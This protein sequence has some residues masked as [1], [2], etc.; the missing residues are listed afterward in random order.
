V[1][2][3]TLLSRAPDRDLGKFRSEVEDEVRY[4]NISI[5]EGIGASQHG[6]GMV[7]A[8]IVETVARDERIVIPIGCYNPKYGV[9]LSLPSVVG[10]EGVLEIIEPE[11]SAD[12]REKLERSADRLKAALN[13]INL[14][15]R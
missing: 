6:I 4:A 1:A 11:L 3:S 9:T 14:S 12:E 8:R 5:I 13:R 7:T 2:I 15:A 10:R